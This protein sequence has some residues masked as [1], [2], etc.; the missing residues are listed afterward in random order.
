[1]GKRIRGG[2]ASKGMIVSAWRGSQAMNFHNQDIER[3]EY[4]GRGRG[5]GF[6]VE[7][8]A[9][10]GGAQLG[11]AFAEGARSI[12]AA[13]LGG[14]V[15]AVDQTKQQLRSYFDSVFTGSGRT[16]NRH[17]RVANAAVQ[18][19]YYVDDDKG[20][21]TGQI[22]SKFG[23]GSG[24]ASF[25]DY[26]L[27]H[28]TGGTVVPRQS[29]WLVLAVAPDMQ[30]YGGLGAVQ[31]GK[32]ETAG[33]SVFFVPSAD[34]QKLFLLRKSLRGGGTELLAVLLKSVQIVPRAGGIGPILEAGGLELERSSER[35]LAQG[36]AG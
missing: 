6:T 15:D 32:F 24:P 27:L 9:L 12:T 21:F 29:D 36:S 8:T 23:R 3:A 35:A 4:Q 1:M 2:E 30:R 22:Y 31:T 34:H 25:V 10:N 14:V 11:E 17:R 7:F 5:S 20:Q 18:S 26:L 13:A 33:T 16:G 19:A 28:V